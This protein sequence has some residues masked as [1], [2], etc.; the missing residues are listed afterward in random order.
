MK[1]RNSLLVILLL[2]I[3][4]GAYSLDSSNCREVI[5]L[6]SSHI[7]SKW[8]VEKDLIEGLWWGELR[9]VVS[10]F[11][12][13][14]SGL[15]LSISDDYPYG[16]ADEKLWNTHEIDGKIFLSISTGDRYYLYRVMQNCDGIILTD[17]NNH[18]HFRLA[19]QG[20]KKHQ[21]FF[22]DLIGSWNAVSYPFT[23]SGDKPEIEGA[24]LS[25]K[26]NE[27]GTFQRDI[28]SAIHH[29]QE[30]GIWHLT[31][32]N[33]YIVLYYFED[34]PKQTYQSEVIRI[35]NKDFGH[36]DL[37]YVIKSKDNSELFGTKAKM[38]TFEKEIKHL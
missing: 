23:L 15:L 8:I 14:K 31:E 35:L 27:D 24:K 4:Q 30:S 16:P 5:N 33:Q 34:N 32:D 18:N 21:N 2:F 25:Y 12:F 20:A 36:L 17:V 19:Y 38:N 22:H 7:A 9:G 26:F 3:W 10:S 37:E 13:N 6:Q 29:Y 28:Q 11:Y 1:S